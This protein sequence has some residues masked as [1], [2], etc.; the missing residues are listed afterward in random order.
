[1]E[2]EELLRR[3]EEHWR[4][5]AAAIGSVPADRRTEPGVVPGWSVRDLVWHCARWSD[6]AAERLRAIASGTYVREDHPDAFYDDLNARWA[7]EAAGVDWDTAASGLI[8]ARNRARAAFEAL[9]QPDADAFEWFTDE[10]AEHYSEHAAEIA[11]F[12]RSG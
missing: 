5:L 11:A 10:A 3:E 6:Y 7:E 8:A 4:S 1:V 9:A 2:R 12:V